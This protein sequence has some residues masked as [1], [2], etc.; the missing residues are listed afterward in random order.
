M[1]SCFPAPIL[2]LAEHGCRFKAGKASRLEAIDCWLCI[3]TEEFC[4]QKKYLRHEV[5]LLSRVHGR[6]DPSQNPAG[7]GIP[8]SSILLPPQPLCNVAAPRLHSSQFP[9]R[10]NPISLSPLF[11]HAWAPHVFELGFVSV[12]LVYGQRPSPPPLN[13]TTGEQGW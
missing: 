6:V 3:M 7:F 12:L 13:S 1:L 9:K 4:K 8:H 5:L 10:S 2:V 11:A